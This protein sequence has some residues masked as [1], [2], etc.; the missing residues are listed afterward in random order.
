MANEIK[1]VFPKAQH[2]LY[3]WHLMKNVQPNGGN[4]FA[5]GFIKCINKYRTPKD[6][7]VGW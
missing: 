7:E 3:L 2:I 4:E 1:V 6:F 5:C